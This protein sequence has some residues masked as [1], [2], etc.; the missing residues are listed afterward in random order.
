MNAEFLYISFTYEQFKFHAQ[1]S[2]KIL[3]VTSGPGSVQLVN[4]VQHHLLGQTNSKIN[5]SILVTAYVSKY[6]V[7]MVS[8]AAL[9]MHFFLFQGIYIVYYL[10]GLAM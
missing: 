6:L 10:Q 3:F 5:I 2:M 8:C 4:S 9:N 1:L 7:K